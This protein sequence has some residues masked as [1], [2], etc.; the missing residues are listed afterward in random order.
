MQNSKIREKVNI[1]KLERWGD[2]NYNN[3]D[4]FKLTSLLKWGKFYTQ[5]DEYKLKSKKSNLEKWGVEY[6]MQSDLVKEKSKL[7]KLERWGDPNYNN[8]DKRVQTNLERWGV[9]YPT[10]NSDIWNKIERTNLKNW[11]VKTILKHGD[12]IE[13]RIK[14]YNENKN[15]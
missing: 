12:V 8:P 4:K 6:V 9:E 3:R 7:T 1:T 11:G 2:P 10:Q 13:K 14:S 15:F 5:T